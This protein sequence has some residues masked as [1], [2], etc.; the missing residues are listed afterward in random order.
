MM[1]KVNENI[2]ENKHEILVCL[3]EMTMLVLNQLM[4]RTTVIL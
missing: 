2:Y 4:K 3:V 1:D